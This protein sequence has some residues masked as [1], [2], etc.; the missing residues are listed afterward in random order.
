MLRIGRANYRANRREAI[1]A[2]KITS[3]AV[4]P[5]GHRFPQWTMRRFEVLKFS[6]RWIRGLDQNEE[7]PARA[8]AGDERRDRIAAKVGIDANS[9][10]SEIAVAEK[11]FRICVRGEA[12]IATF[13]IRNRNQSE[14]ARELQHF[15]KCM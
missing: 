15:D 2:D 5:F 8:H 10:A 14:R 9:I 3:P 11:G 1:D 13:R 7:S 4:N 12:N 6:R